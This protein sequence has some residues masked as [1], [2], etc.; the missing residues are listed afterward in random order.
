MDFAAL[1]ELKLM[2]VISFAALAALKLLGPDSFAALAA[3]SCPKNGPTNRLRTVGCADRAWRADC[4]M[5]AIDEATVCSLAELADALSESPERLQAFV[6]ASVICSNERGEFP[7][8]FVDR[9]LRRI[10]ARRHCCSGQRAEAI[11]DAECR[12]RKTP[13]KRDAETL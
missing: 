3:W 1:A 11:L 2:T 5:T 9:A 13:R 8:M 12:V 10:L 7:L 6:G 4:A